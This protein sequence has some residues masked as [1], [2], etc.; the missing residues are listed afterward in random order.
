MRVHAD[1]GDKKC[2]ASDL[3]E[4][5]TLRACVGIC[6]VMLHQSTD[7]NW[8]ETLDALIGEFTVTDY[9]DVT[10][11]MSGMIL[12]LINVACHR[13]PEFRAAGMT[14]EAYLERLGMATEQTAE[15]MRRR[16]EDDGE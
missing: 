2:G 3:T 13:I 1:E 10:I 4:D 15:F 8:R 5:D 9:V 16:R 7:P 12:G 6:T 14:P 11:H